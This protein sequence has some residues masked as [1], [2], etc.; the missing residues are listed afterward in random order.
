MRKLI[1][2]FLL[3][4]I[5]C[6]AALSQNKFI[7]GKVTNEKNEPLA[8]A[9][10][11]VK[12]GKEGTLT[13]DMGKFSL[14]VVLLPVTLVISFAEL[15]PEEV[16]VTTA[17]EI[18][19]TLQ[20]FEKILDAVVVAG[21]RVE[22]KLTTS[23][24]SIEKVG[25]A[26][27]INAPGGIYDLPL[28][29]KGL[30]VTLSSLTYKTYSTRGFNG[31]GSSRV[32]QLMDG[33]DNQAPG[34]NFSVGNFV[35]LSDLDIE[36]IEILPGA[37]S[38]LYGPGGVNGT[39][40]L[41]SKNP[42]K[43]PGL[44]VQVKNGVT[45]VGKYQRD[46]T[47]FYSDYTLRWAKS[48]NDKFAFKIGAQYM[49]ANDWLANDTSNYL[50]SGANGKV[51]AGTRQ[52]D[53]NYD[54]V[55]VYGDETSVDIRAFMQGAIQANPALA[56]ILQPFLGSA[57]LVSRTGY[58]EIY[59][60]SP[61][62]ENIK[63]SGALHY[64][65]TPKLEG[66]IAGHW[67]SGN[68][69]YTGNGRYAFKDIKVGQYK[70][71][72]K[73][74]NWFLRGYTTQEDAG[75]AYSAGIAAQIFN[76]SWKRSF[77]PA[78]IN[79]S[80]YP[81]YTG[82]FVTGAAQVFQSVFNGTNL[83]QAQA[84]V[85]AAAPQLHAAGRGFA[86]VGRPAGGS[87]QFQQIFDQVRKIPIPGGGLFKE[88]SQL[89][90]G[91]GQYNFSEK[92]KFAEI[93]V[94]GNIKNY[95]LDSEST[96]FY[97][98]DGPIKI[99]EW[100][101][102]A[103]IT[104]RLLEDKLVLSAAGRYDKNENFDGKFTPRLTALLKVAEGHNVR[105]SYQ[106]AYK[107]PTTQQQ[108]I[109]L[110]IGTVVL[111]GGLPWINDVMNV[112][113]NPTFIYNPPAASVPFVY[114][115]LKPESM[116]S[117]EIGYKSIINKKLLLD[118]YAYFGK[119]SDFHGRI[120]VVQ[121]TTT[122]KPFSI[123]TNSETEIKAWGAGIGFD[124][125]MA[126]NYFSFFNVFTDNLT[127]VP[128]GFQAGFNTPKYRINAGFGNSGL[129]KKELIGFN[130]NLRWQD[131]FFWEGAGFIDGTVKAY[132]TL[133]A[134]VNYKLKKIKSQIKLGGT[135]ITNNFY[136]TGFGNPYIGGMYYLSLAYNI[137]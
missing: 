41:N 63:L 60:I 18:N 72:L 71:E 67:A 77:N 48:F 43:S 106:T 22:R 108:W 73:H 52:S 122:N 68:T 121:P 109:N 87:S 27:I 75:E 126:K 30:D 40:I 44:S 80:W 76:E 113:T 53:P 6:I 98:P 59:T 137:L 7:T 11:K 97:E 99:N 14:T 92:I 134:Q 131:E 32:N 36:S 57:Q 64:K 132:T 17:G 33:M 24:I 105:V 107:F 35:G 136:Q 84:A 10:V 104:K 15:N 82:A 115:K 120:I 13:D 61:K 25:K 94:G 2:T 128:S 117:F 4:C 83:A 79:G 45:D 129:G 29:K 16:T 86:D 127:N 96:L 78:N 123:V 20:T 54:G 5:G 91:E 58:D 85:L 21:D 119:Y 56:P 74:R 3:A 55:N 12:N 116:R 112:K 39:I 114:K 124:Y 62:T 88:T 38:A 23:A 133:D 65:F 89:W 118:M 31:S 130:I 102:Y 125:K 42:F 95:I 34:L 110:D 19:I 8:K 28:Y 111:L 135:N 101:A 46:K 81:Q 66:I 50:R 37:S 26:E 69:V 1:L 100:G 47:G 90:M 9:T 93:I 49:K 103:Q 51:V 70:V